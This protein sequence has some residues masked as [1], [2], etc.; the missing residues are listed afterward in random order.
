MGAGVD[1]P[2]FVR[3]EGVFFLAHILR[4]LSDEIV[5]GCTSWYAD[6][7]LVIPPR[8]ASTL[9]L[10]Y[11]RGPQ[12]VTDI[13]AALR[14][15]HPLVIQWVKQ[16]AALGVVE[17]N[18]GKD[19]RRR[20]IVSLSALG[21]QQTERLVAAHETF[22]RAYDQLACDADADPFDALW[23]LEEALRERPFADRLR[24]AGSE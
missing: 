12:S 15:S 2:D 3:E 19:D 24:V 11:R 21:L 1:E 13:A 4:R 9:H 5:E 18:K 20:T 8:T 16:L 22:A 10:L 6:M 14:Q 17:T 23:R 7:G